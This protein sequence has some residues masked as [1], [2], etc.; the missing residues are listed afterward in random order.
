MEG[1]AVVA[2]PAVKDGLFGVTW[3]RTCLMEGAL[4]VMGFTCGVEVKRLEINC[5]VGLAILFGTYDH[6]VAP[7]DGLSYRHRFKDTQRDVLVESCLDF[8]LPVEWYWYWS[9]M[10]NW[11]CCR[12]NH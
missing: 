2:I 9:V 3:N 4:R 12:V 6:A 10:C 8:F 1:N 11:F 7:C 5:A